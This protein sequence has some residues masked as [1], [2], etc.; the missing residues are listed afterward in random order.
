MFEFPLPFPGQ[1][2]DRETRLFYNYFRDCDR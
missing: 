2:F 1:Y